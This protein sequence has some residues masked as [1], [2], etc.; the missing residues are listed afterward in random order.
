ML[1]YLPYRP[2][3]IWDISSIGNV[4]VLRMRYLMFMRVISEPSD[5]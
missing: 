2:N 5:A 4:L 1:R 3:F